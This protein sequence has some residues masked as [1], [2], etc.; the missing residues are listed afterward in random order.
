MAFVRYFKN[1][2]SRFV[3][4]LRKNRTTNLISLA[5]WARRRWR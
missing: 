3:K 4:I 1:A 2:S 5:V